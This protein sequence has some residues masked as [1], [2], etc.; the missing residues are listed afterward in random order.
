M[1]KEG[2]KNNNNIKCAY[3]VDK[4]HIIVY[5]DNEEVNGGINNG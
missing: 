3:Y 5:N 1:Q 2:V 4:I